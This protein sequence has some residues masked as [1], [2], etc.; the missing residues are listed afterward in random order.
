MSSVNRRELKA[1]SD[2]LDSLPDSFNDEP[3]ELI[4]EFAKHVEKNITD[5]RVKFAILVHLYIALGKYKQ[6]SDKG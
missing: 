6:Y 5:R 3:T 4:D 1:L 2:F